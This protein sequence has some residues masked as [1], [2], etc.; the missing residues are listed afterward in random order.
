MSVS[1]HK[2]LIHGADIIK[3][4]SVPIGKL[5]E[6][7]QEAR[8]KDFKRTREFN[9]RKCSRIATNTDVL[10]SLLISSDPYI[11]SLRK[12]QQKKKKVCSQKF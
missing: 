9:T 11:T 2:I 3:N 1:V 12:I 6:E 4:L 8:N 10:H 5:S 7:A